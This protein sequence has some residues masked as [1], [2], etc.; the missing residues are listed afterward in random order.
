[1]QGNKQG[2]GLPGSGT[3]ECT[4]RYFTLKRVQNVFIQNNLFVFEHIWG[5]RPLGPHGH[6]AI[7][8]TQVLAKPVGLQCQQ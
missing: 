1:M 8:H 4:G 2:G 3:W 7:G 5:A 6:D